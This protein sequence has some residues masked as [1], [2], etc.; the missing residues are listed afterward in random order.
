MGTVSVGG[1]K[2]VDASQVPVKQPDKR[3]VIQ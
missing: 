3:K 2:Q 1:L